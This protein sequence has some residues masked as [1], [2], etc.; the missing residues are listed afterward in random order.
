MQQLHS[1]CLSLHESW[2][3]Q[4]GA[5]TPNQAGIGIF[6]PISVGENGVFFFDA[7]ANVSDANAE[8]RFQPFELKDSILAPS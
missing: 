8:K 6:L 7:L 3:I 5:G 1:F 4:P 2:R